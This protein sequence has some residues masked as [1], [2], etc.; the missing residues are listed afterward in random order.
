MAQRRAGTG[1]EDG[2][3]PAPVAAQYWVADRV[4]AAVYAVQ[5]PRRDAMRDGTTSQSE[6]LELPPRDYPML[7]RRETRD[8]PIHAANDV[9]CTYVVHFASFVEDDLTVAKNSAR[10]G[11]G[12]CRFSSGAAPT[13]HGRGAPKAARDGGDRRDAGGPSLP[14]VTAPRGAAAP[15]SLAARRREQEPL[16]GLSPAHQEAGGVG[17]PG[18]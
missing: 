15:R 7:A 1:S 11:R 17:G 12:S 18:E 5:T 9:F 16:V 4:D 13:L 2:C 14:S 6:R 8:P 3:H 10:V